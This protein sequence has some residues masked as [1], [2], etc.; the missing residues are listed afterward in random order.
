MG[1]LIRIEV[2]LNLEVVLEV[3]RGHHNVFVAENQMQL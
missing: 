2:R 1:V 3:L